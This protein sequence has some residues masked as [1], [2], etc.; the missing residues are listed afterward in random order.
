MHL[1]V[2]KVKVGLIDCIDKFPV[3]VS[4]I[5]MCFLTKE[6]LHLIECVDI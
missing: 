3:C 1:H 4:Y 2:Y 5:W 6:I